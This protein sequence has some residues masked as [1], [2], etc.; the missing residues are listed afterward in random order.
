MRLKGFYLIFSFLA[1]LIPGFSQD[2]SAE[3]T[4]NEI[5]DRMEARAQSLAQRMQEM[6]GKERQS[7][8][9]VNPAGL[10]PGSS[11]SSPPSPP[12]SS[13]V[14][15]GSGQNFSPTQDSSIRENQNPESSNEAFSVVDDSD[16][17][18]PIESAQELLGDYYISPSIGFV[19]SSETKAAFKLFSAEKVQDLDNEMGYGVGLRAG[20]RFDN[21]YTEVGLKYSSLDYKITGIHTTPGILPGTFID[22]NYDGIGSVDILNFNAKLGYSYSFNEVLSFNGSVGLGLSNRRNEL[23]IAAGPDGYPPIF[24]DRVSSSETVLSYDLAFSINYFVAESYLISLGYNYM[25]VGKI[26]QFDALNLHY[27]ELGMGLN[28]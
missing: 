24:N 18:L 4:R 13:A 15:T 14:I 19:L 8:T 25:N 23:Y 1:S 9:R 7:P 2:Q 28:F 3:P 22:F 12:T 26:S 11:P 16:D 5:F 10:E 27:F 20:I 21:F 17:Y 6:S